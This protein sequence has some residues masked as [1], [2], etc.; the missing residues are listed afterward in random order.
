MDSTYFFL[1][2]KAFYVCYKLVNNLVLK[3]VFTNFA[4]K[5]ILRFDKNSF[6]FIFENKR[7]GSIF[8][9]DLD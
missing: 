8:A 7:L 4:T 5:I 2:I 9:F 3:K 1:E 6:I